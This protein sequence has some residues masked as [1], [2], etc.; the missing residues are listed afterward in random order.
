VLDAV[1]VVGFSGTPILEF[2]RAAIDPMPFSL[3]L[4]IGRAEP[5]TKA[6]GQID[7]KFI[8]FG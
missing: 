2:E 4:L 8:F 7:Q 1:G 5:G 3:L 6:V